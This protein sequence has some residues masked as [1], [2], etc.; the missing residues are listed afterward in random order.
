MERSPPRAPAREELHELLE[1]TLAFYAHLGA[2]R[3]ASKTQHESQQSEERLYQLLEGI[4]KRGDARTLVLAYGSWGLVAGRPEMA[5]NKG[6][7]YCIGV[8]LLRKLADKRFVV[9]IT[10]E[11]WTSKTCLQVLG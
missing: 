2:G 7:P 8:G 11:A 9:A 10:P 6:M 1:P 5:C 4:Q 3:R